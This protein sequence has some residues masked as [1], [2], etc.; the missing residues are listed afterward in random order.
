MN[1]RTSLIIEPENGRFPLHPKAPNSAGATGILNNNFDGPETRPPERALP[2]SRRRLPT[3]T[4]FD[5]THI[6]NRADEDY[7]GLVE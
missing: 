1:W 6:Q 2:A 4:N 3:M 5:G 7:V